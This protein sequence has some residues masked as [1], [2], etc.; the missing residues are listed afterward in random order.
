MARKTMPTLFLAVLMALS[1]R[2][3]PFPV[4]LG[5]A[6][7]VR[8]L[9]DRSSTAAQSASYDKLPLSF[10]ANLGQTDPQVS[11]V[12][13]GGGY[14]LFLAPTE[15]VLALS[16]PDALR[17][18]GKTHRTRPSAAEDTYAKADT[19]LRIRF[20]GANP[21][22]RVMG[23]E[24]LPGKVNYFIGNDP[25]RWRTNIPTYARV[26]TEAVYRGIDVIFYGNQRNLEYDVV[27][28]PGADASNIRL[29]VQGAGKLHVDARGDL[30]LQAAGGHLRM[31]RPLVYQVAG[32]TRHEIA[33]DYV[34]LPAA[35]G[36]GQGIHP[37]GFRVGA[38]DPALPLVI[39]PVLSY[40]TYLGG[41]GH[42]S[43]R[44]IAVDA[45]GS[46][47]VIGSTN[48][49]DFP[50]AHAVQ[51]G[52]MG[53]TEPPPE[54]GSA[55]DVFV[56]KLNADGSAL[57]YATYLGGSRGD[58]GGGIAVDGEGN[59]YLTGSTLSP[60]FP[61]RNP[62]QPAFGGGGTSGG[63]AF[64]AKLDPAGSA[65]VYATYLGGSGGDNPL[66]EGEGDIAVDT[67][68][69]AYVTGQTLS[70]DFPTRNPLQPAFASEPHGG[71]DAFVTK[72][73]A[74][75]SAVVYATYLGG[76]GPDGGWG[77]AVDSQGN[78]YVMGTTG[79]S[80]FPTVNPLQPPGGLSDVFV[81]KLNPR[82][83]A[84]VYATHLGGS[85]F[86]YGSGGIAVDTAGNAL[87]AGETQSPD[88]PTMNA[89]QEVYGGGTV[90]VFVAKLDPAGSAL[91]YATFI[92][93]GGYDSGQAI[94]VDAEGNAHVAGSTDSP[95][96]PTANA[97]Q[98][99]F[100][101]GSATGI[102]GPYAPPDA[103]VVKLHP[104]GTFRYST[105]LGGSG[106]DGAL[107]IAVDATGHAYVAGSTNSSDFP[108]ATPLQAPG[109]GG[110]AQ[111]EMGGPPSDAFVVQLV[112]TGPSEKVQVAPR[113]AT[114]APADADIATGAA[115][116]APAANA[117]PVTA[118]PGTTAGSA[119][120][121][122]FVALLLGFVGSMLLLGRRAS[123][124]KR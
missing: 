9:L 10:E 2:G 3:T 49:R 103:F 54:G 46:A 61:T 99:A 62:L 27:L 95:D 82:G 73:N 50:T 107:G 52:F 97:A 6:P 118:P 26:K 59:A 29:D 24:E 8:P 5:T 124:R 121:W 68:G 63:D 112:D 43:A 84:L 35:E 115:I 87:V 25:R 110:A 79:P 89:V 17:T 55:S 1:G 18:Q 41:N 81:A 123:R 11:F 58:E 102:H 44:D 113:A 88:F 105:Y 23:L 56:A 15:V 38:Y 86:D 91:V 21:Q 77:I 100:G 116:S 120:G 75:G 47:Y 66:G 57:V 98:P 119:F 64:V 40:A 96:F 36:A 53:P 117:A 93:G 114:A 51:P 16:K 33:G 48:S 78:T 30:L 32:G 28:A 34:L 72:L 42:D 19:E 104:M 94:A 37:V 71:G 4:P 45:A 70:P 106:G 20:A 101:G 13:R 7:A 85:G 65:L 14:R 76:P 83:S 122:M 109:S 108:T 39:D 22:P 67:G 80:G 92:G 31:H 60:D 90:D 111:Q 69:N 12:S 74:A